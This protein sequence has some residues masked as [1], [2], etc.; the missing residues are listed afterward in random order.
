[1]SMR[2]TVE[3][4]QS[5]TKCKYKIITGENTYGII[6]G[7]TPL[8]GR[9]STLMRYLNDFTYHLLS[10]EHQPLEKSIEHALFITSQYDTDWIGER[11]S[12]AAAITRIH[13]DL[14][15]LAKTGDMTIILYGKKTT[16]I[17][18]KETWEKTIKNIQSS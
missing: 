5:S 4:V 14:I 3:T 15:E 7:V 18:V 9:H 2:Y 13:D 16:I 11:P 12:A 6:G 8:K 17:T 10:N 1:M